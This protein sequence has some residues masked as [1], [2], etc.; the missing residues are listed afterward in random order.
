MGIFTVIRSVPPG[1][2]APLR[3][4]PVIPGPFLP[5]GIAAYIYFIIINAAG[6]TFLS[7]INYLIPVV[8]FFLGALL[9]GEE[10]LLQN[11]LALLFI[12]S[13]IF[14]SRKNS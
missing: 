6:A 1:A 3:G 13:G 10:I 7:N 11:I 5:T 4:L 9:L 14:I 8:A 2:A 12:I